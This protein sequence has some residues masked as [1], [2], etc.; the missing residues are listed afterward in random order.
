VT[1]VVD[2]FVESSGS[3]MRLADSIAVVYPRAG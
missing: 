3:T 2:E 1:P